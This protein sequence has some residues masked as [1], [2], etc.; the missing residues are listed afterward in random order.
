MYFYVDES[1]HSGPNLFDKQ[2]P[3]LYYGT[4]S[5]PFDVDLIA[6][7]TIRQ[8]RSKLRVHRIHAN[9]L[10]N[11]GLMLIADDLERLSFDLQLRVRLS[12]VLKP[13]HAIITFF[14]QVFDQGVNPANSYAGYWTPL[15]YLL[16]FTLAELFDEKLAARAWDARLQ[17][18]S[19]KAEAEV[20]SICN[21]L[22]LRTDGILDP[23]MRELIAD[24]LRWAAVNPNKLG[25]NATNNTSRLAAMPNMIGFQSVLMAI[26]SQL[27]HSNQQARRIV[28]DRQS[29]FNTSQKSL[30]EYYQ[31]ISK[32]P[33]LKETGLPEMDLAG[34]PDIPLEFS[35]GDNCIGLELVDIY[36]WIARRV[37]EGKFVTQRLRF[38][39]VNGLGK[40]IGNE[41]SLEA[42][43]NQ[44]LPW[45]SQLPHPT[46][47][48]LQS[49]AAYRQLEEQ[50]RQSSLVDI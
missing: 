8:I 44:W 48:Q 7:P 11:D 16:L 50:R 33:V 25:Y 38:F 10:G 6:G 20:T 35:G 22:A 30:H 24:T 17:T 43:K 21:T 18:N 32:A 12:T 47:E 29:Q 37:F 13:D 49:I 28:I 27:N 5:S 34:L 1:G 45:F 41:V 3:R 4:L 42:L 15:R 26:A 40:S 39:A 19:S 14:D 46:A 31:A 2:Q 36:L 9:E 23:R